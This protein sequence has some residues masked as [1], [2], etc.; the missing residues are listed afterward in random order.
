MTI[1]ELISN[2]FLS[3]LHALVNFQGSIPQITSNEGDVGIMFQVQQH[4]GV[5]QPNSPMEI[6]VIKPAMSVVLTCLVIDT[7]SIL[8]YG[9]GQ[10]GR[11]NL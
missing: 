9:S 10:I 7:R 1:N 4:L 5:I 8:G 3:Y 6:Y 2:V 11:Y